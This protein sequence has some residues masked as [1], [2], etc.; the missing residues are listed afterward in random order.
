MKR[1]TDEEKAKK[2]EYYRKNKDRI[3]ARMKKHYAEHKDEICSRNRKRYADNREE[4]LNKRRAYN[5]K[6]K[7]RV[8][9]WNHNW[10]VEHRE[11]QLEYAKRYAAQRKDENNAKYRKRRQMLKQMSVDYLGGSCA[12]CGFC[13]HISALEFHHVDPGQ[14][15]IGISVLLD[16]KRKKRN[17]EEIKSELDKCIVLCR[18]CHARL[19]W[20]DI[21]LCDCL[22]HASAALQ[23]GE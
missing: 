18:N 22:T 5:E 2:R 8:K 17:I 12:A 6:N 21:T 1:L 11:Q 4:M 3:L 10:Y 9:E 20:G 23:H 19:H 14:K 16:E 13:E 15:E 7:L